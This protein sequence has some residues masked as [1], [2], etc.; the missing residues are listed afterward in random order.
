MRIITE[1]QYKLAQKRVEDFLWL[2]TAH[3]WMTPRP[4]S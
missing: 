1:N 4:L 3:H 2:M